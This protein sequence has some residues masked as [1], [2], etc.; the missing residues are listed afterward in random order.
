ML[1][2][3]ILTATTKRLYEH[4][5]Y[6]ASRVPLVRREEFRPTIES[7][8]RAF[9]LPDEDLCVDR[10]SLRSDPDSPQRSRYQEA[11]RRSTMSR[12]GY[13]IRFRD[14]DGW[15][16][17]IPMTLLQ[18]ANFLDRSPSYLRYKLSHGRG[19]WSMSRARGHAQNDVQLIQVLT[20]KAYVKETAATEKG[21]AHETVLK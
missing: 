6:M 11:I 17:P 20:A 4:L 14:T 7:I 3:P 18:A 8:Q 1:Q 10:R 9:S 21:R 2:K 16:D 15:T 12:K 13:W 5:A 19:R